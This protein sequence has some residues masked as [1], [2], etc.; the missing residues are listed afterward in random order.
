MIALVPIRD[1][2]L[3][4]GASEAIAECDGRA[5]IAGSGTGSVDLDGLAA[6]VR[7]V[8]LGPVEPARW[9]AALTALLRQVD[10]GDIV[11]LPHSPDGLSLIHI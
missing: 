5:I 8:E 11:V 2:V 1:G 9:T 4:A 10:D 7:L 6:K 3:P